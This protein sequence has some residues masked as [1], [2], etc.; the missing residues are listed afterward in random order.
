MHLWNTLLLSST[1]PIKGGLA[2]VTQKRWFVKSKTT[3]S[4]AHSGYSKIY[5][6]CQT[7]SLTAPCLSRKPC[8][9][10]KKGRTTGENKCLKVP[11]LTPPDLFL[12]IFTF[13]YLCITFC[14]FSPEEK[15]SYFSIILSLPASFQTYTHQLFFSTIWFGSS[16]LAWS[17]SCSFYQTLN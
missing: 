11:S 9:C 8:S 15:S 4:N 10:F 7:Y 1:P 6:F 16:A 12:S 2:T 5:P 13:I 3:S 14:F 17:L